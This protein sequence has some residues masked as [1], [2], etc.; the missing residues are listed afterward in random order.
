MSDE[1]LRYEEEKYH[2]EMDREEMK[3]PR[4]N[5][6][7]HK[8]RRDNSER[9]DALLAECEKMED[10]LKENR[11]LQIRIYNSGYQSGHHD[12]V[13]GC[14]VIVHDCDKESYHEEEVDELVSDFYNDR[15]QRGNPYHSKP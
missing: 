7:Y 14:F 15:P 13:E 11:K 2:Y 1:Q 9:I 12:T 8:A 4:T 5:N 6:A 10:E 3:Y